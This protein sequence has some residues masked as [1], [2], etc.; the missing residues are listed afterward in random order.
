MKI[1]CAHDELMDID[2]LVPHPRN[3]N[4][5]G[6]RQIE[7]LAKIMKH[8]GWRSPITVSTRSGYIVAGHAR[9][10]AARLNGWDK[11]P[12]D[13]QDFDSEADEYSHIVADNKIAAL[14]SHDDMMMIDAIKELEIDDFELMGMPD[15]S[16]EDIPISNTGAELNVNDFDNFDHECPK[17]GF[18]WSDNGS[19]N[20]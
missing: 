13:K 7:L 11:V 10:E 16:I 1:E 4:K 9:L 19:D 6:D 18:E 3:P 15:F 12:V 20:S 17:C 2:L 5:H 14:A 8:R